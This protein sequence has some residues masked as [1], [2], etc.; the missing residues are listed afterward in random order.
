MRESIISARVSPIPTR[1]P[2]GERHVFLARER[3]GLDACPRPL[4]RCLVVRTARLGEAWAHVLE[5][6]SHGSTHGTQKGQLST[7]HRTQIQMGQEPNFVDDNRRG[8]CE[9][10]PGSSDI[11]AAL[12]PGLGFG[13]TLLGSFA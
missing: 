3:Q 9:H 5:H 10:T 12:Q 6:D 7:A 1:E 11:P 13:V 8:I 2:S 4:A